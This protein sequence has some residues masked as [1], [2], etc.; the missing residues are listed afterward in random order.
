M[1]WEGCLDPAANIPP[2]T[3]GLGTGRRESLAVKWTEAHSEDFHNGVTSVVSGEPEWLGSGHLGL[4]TCHQGNK[5]LALK[6]ERWVS[7]PFWLEEM[8]GTVPCLP[9][10]SESQDIKTRR[11]LGRTC[12]INPFYRWEDWGQGREGGLSK[13]HQTRSK[14][15]AWTESWAIDNLK[16]KIPYTKGQQEKQ[17]WEEED[18]WVSDA[19]D[20]KNSKF[21]TEE[22]TGNGTLMQVYKCW[23]NRQSPLRESS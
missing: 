2:A 22:A 23:R 12:P 15:Q 14:V 13:A 7:S 3:R 8:W 16:P 5:Y 1:A 19:G 18:W 9:L 4:R 11:A 10:V 17:L 6:A 20:G 21:S